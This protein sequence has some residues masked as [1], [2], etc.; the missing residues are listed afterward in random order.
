MT[1]GPSSPKASAANRSPIRS[2]TLVPLLGAIE[3]LTLI[4]WGREDGIIPLG[5][6]RQYQQAIKGARAVVL[7]DCGHLSEI[8]QREEFMSA[9]RAFLKEAQPMAQ[10]AAGASGRMH[11]RSRCTERRHLRTCR[12]RRE[13]RLCA[14][15]LGQLDFRT[16]LLRRP[17]RVREDNVVR[18]HAVLDLKDAGDLALHF[19]PVGGTPKNSTAGVPVHVQRPTTASSE[20]MMRSSSSSRSGMAAR[21]PLTCCS[22]PAHP[23]VSLVWSS[24]SSA[25]S[26][27]MSSSLS[28]ATTSVR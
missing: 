19:T 16:H 12:P 24:I 20:A 3:T 5:V 7:D 2:R 15:T 9:V 1:N 14:G 21:N 22:S 4:V 18:E 11:R 17:K 6:C 26:S 10:K 23:S 8:E 13:S 27:G 25:A 28:C